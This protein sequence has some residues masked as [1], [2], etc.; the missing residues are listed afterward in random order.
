MKMSTLYRALLHLYPAS[1]RK[2]FSEEMICVFE[3]RAG[4]RFANRKSASIVFLFTEFSGIV[5]GAIIMWLARILA[6]Q[7]NPSSSNAVNSSSEPLSIA[8]VAT[9]RDT[10]IRNMVAA[11]TQHDFSNARTYSYEEARLKRLLQDMEKPAPVG[12]STTA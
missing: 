10:A 3:Q 2:Q 12:H 5:R 6:A 1:F 7:R 11:I 9:Q 4:E 8:Q